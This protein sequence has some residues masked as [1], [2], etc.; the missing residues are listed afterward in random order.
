MILSSTV[1]IALNAFSAMSKIALMSCVGVFLAKYPK[2]KPIMNLEFIQTLSKLSNN[3]FVPC[4]ILTSLG[5]GVNLDLL[6]RIG[7][8]VL[9]CAIINLISFFF[10]HT[11]GWWLHGRCKDDMYIALAVAIGSPNAISLPIMVL[12]TMCENDTINLD[13][14]SNAKQCYTEGTSMLFV[15]SIGWH[16]M[17]WSY[18]FPILKSLKEKQ[19]LAGTTGESSPSSAP[20]TLLPVSDPTL[21]RDDDTTNSNN[22]TSN[23]STLSLC[24]PKVLQAMKWF[25]SVLLTPAMMAIIGGVTISL[26]PPLQLMLFE[27]ISVFR[28][29]GSAITT[30][31]EPVVAT[32]CLIMSASLANVDLSR[33]RPQVHTTASDGVEMTAAD[34]DKRDKK[35]AKSYALLSG[36][37]DESMHEDIASPVDLD[38]EK[39]EQK[40]GPLMVSSSVDIV[41]SF[42]PPV[43]DVIPLPS[44]R[45]VAALILCRLVLPPLIVIYALLPLALHFHVLRMEDRLMQFIIAIESAS[46]SAQVIIVSLNQLG[47]TK[48]ASDMSYMYVFQF[49]SSIFTISFWATVA[50][51]NIY[52]SP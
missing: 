36:D 3:V 13:Y 5:S 23:S 14:G 24:K 34:N 7:V 12:Q 20:I 27:D 52:I 4:L 47:L 9:F 22:S 37:F 42:I 41:P 18:G 35:M 1:E 51:S 10:A 25:Q 44:W 49:T 32:S 28:P 15:Y 33:G 11:L 30:L 39:E 50:M 6:S 45:S 48:I 16:L 43:V 40:E 29:L 19:L 46:S 17:F 26:I 38:S 2:H 31:G 8:L 21:L